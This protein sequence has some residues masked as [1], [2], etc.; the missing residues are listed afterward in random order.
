MLAI[1]IAKGYSNLFYV[2]VSMWFGESFAQGESGNILLFLVLANQKV[3][4]NE[5][6]FKL[7]LKIREKN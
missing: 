1:A 4:S 7:H 6:S 3:Y 5:T 2:F